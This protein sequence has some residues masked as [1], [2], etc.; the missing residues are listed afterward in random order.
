ML[1]HYFT[2]IVPAKVKTL[3]L[4]C[5]SYAGQ[6]KNW[7]VIRYLHYLT[8]HL[9]RFDEI[10]I[11]FP[12][13]GHSYM[14]C[15]RDMAVINQKARVEVRDDWIREFEA[16]RKNPSPFNVV[17]ANQSMFLGMAQHLKN[18]YR[19][20]C[21]VPT[22]PIRDIVFARQHPRLIRFRNK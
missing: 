5:D 18:L 19:A 7:T 12:I 1:H 16:A 13:R 2:T 10:K 4:F 6:N 21:Q 22:R 9:Q 17:R 20:A 8:A 14:E 15:D 11:S 3:E